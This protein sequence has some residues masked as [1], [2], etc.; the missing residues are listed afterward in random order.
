MI[1]AEIQVE[2]RRRRSLGPPV[3]HL[4]G[5]R[6]VG[7]AEKHV[8]QAAVDER[9]NVRGRHVRASF[10]QI[11]NHESA[12]AVLAGLRGHDAD[13]RKQARR[14]IGEQIVGRRIRASAANRR[15]APR[16]F[17]IAAIFRQAFVRR[18]SS[19]AKSWSA[20]A[21]SPGAQSSARSS[22][23][24]VQFASGDGGL[25]RL[26]I[27]PG[28]RSCGSPIWRI[29]SAAANSKLRCV[30]GSRANTATCGSKSIWPM[31]QPVRAL[32][33]SP[34][35]ASARADRPDRCSP[36]RTAVRPDRHQGPDRTAMSRQD[37]QKLVASRQQL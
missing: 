30:F 1:G 24:V 7:I 17:P 31:R 22:E 13:V 10:R 3:A 28:R 9:I 25:R 11:D 19:H 18:S 20:R 36:G 23:Q 35:R 2:L 8:V 33:V 34:P 12:D 16:S 32:C 14:K 15:V 4:L 26:G 37:V 6:R 29:V 27:C 21:F 5:D